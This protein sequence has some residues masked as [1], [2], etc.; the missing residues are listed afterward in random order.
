MEGFRSDNHRTTGLQG[1]GPDSQRDD[2]EMETSVLRTVENV[3]TIDSA[4]RLEGKQDAGRE[5]KLQCS[6]RK[7]SVDPYECSE[8]AVATQAHPA[9]ALMFAYPETRWL[10]PKEGG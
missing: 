10:L 9:L 5:V 4:E 1:V 7:A 6:H 8:T 3:P 2:S